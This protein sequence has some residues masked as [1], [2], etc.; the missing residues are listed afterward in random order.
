MPT[1]F[2]LEKN[3]MDMILDFDVWFYISAYKQ[4]IV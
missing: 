2:I 4:L 3:I 1:V